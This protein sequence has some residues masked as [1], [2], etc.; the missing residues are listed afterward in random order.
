MTSAGCR[1]S[2]PLEPDPKESISHEPAA[3]AEASD[4]RRA[5]A[6]A[7]DRTADTS[8]WRRGVGTSGARPMTWMEVF[9]GVRLSA[10]S[11]ANLVIQS[12]AWALSWAR[13]GSK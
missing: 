3:A 6:T 7:F 10:R 11:L 4:A 12:L 9:L 13:P 1:H 2:L 8:H 5:S